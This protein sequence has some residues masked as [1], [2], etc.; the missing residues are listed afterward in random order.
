M[1][2][3]SKKTKAVF[4]VGPTASGKT[5]LGIHIAKHFNGEIV[6]A[7][8]M[9]IYNGIHIASAAPDVEEMQGIPHHLLEFLETDD[10]FSVADYVK[11]A[12]Q[13]IADIADRG[14]LPVIV[15]GTGLYINSLID[16]TEFV[17]EAVDLTLRNR[18]EKRF[19]LLG[20]E[21]MLDELSEIDKE[22]A[23][24]L[25][26]NDRRRIIRAFEIYYSTGK[27]V[28]EQNLLS[29]STPSFV[30][31]LILGITFQNRAL[32]YERI[33]RRV[34]LMLE[35]GLLDEARQTLNRVGGSGAFQAIGHKEL[36]CY[37][38]G[39]CSLAEASELLKQQ[40]RRYA[41]R[42]LT[43][44]RRDDRINWI[45]ADHD[46]PSEKGIELVNEF[47]KEE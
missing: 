22:T 11:L 9:Q 42:Q 26:P 38:K 34:D 44:F 6:S 43:W 12:R 1:A 24:R 7:D 17:E 35:R 41:K 27:T 19:E 30:E 5:E 39:E 21:M 33:N 10:V 4:V 32:L 15:G 37:L 13:C 31:P 8:S 46:N 29:H 2:E 47:L 40:T 20:G 18:L 14:K 3:Y 25:H 16:N 28:T 36:Y 23:K 45:Y